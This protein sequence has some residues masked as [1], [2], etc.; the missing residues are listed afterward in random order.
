MKSNRHKRF[1]AVDMVNGEVL[2]Y[3]CEDCD[4]QFGYG[5]DPDLFPCEKIEVR[6]CRSLGWSMERY[7]R[8]ARSGI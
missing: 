2:L 5:D 7:L 8:E 6:M 1:K 3:V 4:Q